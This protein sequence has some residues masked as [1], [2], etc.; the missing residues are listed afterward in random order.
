EASVR[1][2]VGRS[3]GAMVKV[4]ERYVAEDYLTIAVTALETPLSADELLAQR[5]EE[6]TRTLRGARQTLSRQ[7]QDEVLRNRLSY[8]A[9]D[10]VIPTWNAAFVYDTEAG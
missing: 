4:R 2:I 3:A 6:L 9:S 8:F 5:P 1:A 7:E 10:L